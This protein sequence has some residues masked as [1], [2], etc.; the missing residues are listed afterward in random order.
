MYNAHYEDTGFS[1]RRIQLKVLLIAAQQHLV[2]RVLTKESKCFYMIQILNH[3][4]V[5]G[6]H[7][8]IFLFDAQGQVCTYKVMHT[9]L[10]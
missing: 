4:I 8:L 1:M 10:C 2:I 6:V 7:C 5:V 3:V 9:F